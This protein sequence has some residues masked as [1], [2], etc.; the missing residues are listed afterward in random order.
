MAHISAFRALRYDP[1]RVSL[2][3]VATQPYDKIT[4]QMR[5]GYYSSSPYNLVRI[6]LGKPDPA[7]QEK[8]NVYTRAAGFFGDWRRQGVFLQDAQSL[9]YTYVERFTAPG[10][11]TEA[12]RRGFIALGRLEDYSAG[13]VLRHEQTLAKPKADRLDLLRE[14]S[15]PF[16]SIFMLY[17][18]PAS[19]IEGLL[20]QLRH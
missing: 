4:P 20:D 17:S 19:E 5:E 15:S 12:V 10:S 11:K 16:W 6:I 3:Q 8:E 18:D 9:I 13:V 2:S 14:H 7:D 1:A